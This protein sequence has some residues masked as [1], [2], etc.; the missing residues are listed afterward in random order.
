MNHYK[1]LT[2][3]ILIRIALIVVV[4]AGFL[5][6]PFI[7]EISAETDKQKDEI[8]NLIINNHV[9]GIEKSKLNTKN[10][11]TIISSLGDPYTQYFSPDE[12][13]QFMDMLENNYVGIGI[14]VGSDEQGFFVNEVFAATPAMGAGIQDGDYIIA[15]E[16]KST[17]GITTDEL[18]SQITG[19]EGTEV[20]ITIQRNKKKINLTMARKAIHIPA[21][22]SRVFDNGTGYIR[23]S[24]FSSDADELFAAKLEEM[25]ADGLKSLV[26]DLRN[27]PGGLLDTAANMASQFIKN[28][29]L[30][31][32]VDRTKKETDYP[33]SGENPLTV[34][35]TVLVNEYSAS[36][37]EVLAGALQDYNLATIIGTKTY[38]KGSVQSLFTLVEGGV[39]KLTI[40]EYLT[41]LRHK[42]NQVG[43][44]PDLNVRGDVSQLVT[45]LQQAGPIDIQLS[46]TQHT[47]SVNEQS[48]NDR[49]KVI[50]E[51]GVTFVPSRVLAA[52]VDG[53]ITWEAGTQS[54]RIK[55]KEDEGA[56]QAGEQGFKLLE[57]VSYI[58]LANF[59][60]QFPTFDWQDK[61]GK[62]L[63][64]E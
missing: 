20:Q 35:V 15:V 51:N 14:R 36:A 34:P 50:R 63:L 54:V 40:Q 25:K 57:G 12:W 4:L 61:D 56:F 27:N 46:L 42:V 49:F 26:V 6:P 28:G 19:V 53:N 47:L 1:Q 32:T 11:D 9:S 7:G 3:K 17:Q 29:S 10:I 43:I 13:K 59:K 30:I 31:H 52:I 44:S 18:I 58:E 24:S 64:L 60:A 39:L 5:S 22:T 23:V 21:L 45:A 2:W 16:G 41:P 33:I 48:F 37:S 62:L 8:V 55:G 38:G